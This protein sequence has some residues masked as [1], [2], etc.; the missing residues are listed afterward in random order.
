MTDLICKVL[1]FLAG[2]ITKFLPTLAIDPAQMASISSG[3]ASVVGFIGKV[4][5]IIPVPTILLILTIV[6]TFK[7]SKFLFFIIN[8]IIRRICD[9]IP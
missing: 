2:M 1:D 4:N 9:L 7:V 5:F 3:V 6:F 8:W